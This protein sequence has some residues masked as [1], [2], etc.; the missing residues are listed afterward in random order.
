MHSVSYHDGSTSGLSLLTSMHF[1]SGMRR[2]VIWSGAIRR[3]RQRSNHF[4]GMAFPAYLHAAPLP[5]FACQNASFSHTLSRS[6]L[7]KASQG[8]N[9]TPEYFIQG[10]DQAAHERSF[11]HAVR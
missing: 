7:P 2:P 8:V 3:G 11:G 10:S 4:F 1:C 9:N 5:H 6:C